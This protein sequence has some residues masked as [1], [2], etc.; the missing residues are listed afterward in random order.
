MRVNRGPGVNRR[1]IYERDDDT[2]QYCGNGASSLDHLVPKLVGGPDRWDNLAASCGTCNMLK[3]DAHYPDL[4]ASM[5]EL[6]LRERTC[7]RNFAPLYWQ[8]QSSGMPHEPIPTNPRRGGWFERT[9]T[10]LIFT[11][12]GRPGRLARRRHD[13]AVAELVERV[14]GFDALEARRELDR[15]VAEERL[16]TT[17]RFYVEVST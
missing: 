10:Q 6:I 13:L 7:R 8:V 14:P 2:C 11:R 9:L 17:P 4:A 3:G 12:P 15:L 1:R 5:R 16:A